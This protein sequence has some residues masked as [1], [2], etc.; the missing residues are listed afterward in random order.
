MI[1]PCLQA[2]LKE[3]KDSLD[4]TLK[5]L[6]DAKTRLREVEEGIAALQAKYE[7]CLAKKEELKE[8]CDLC[9]AR[10][11]RAEKVSPLTVLI[12]SLALM[13]S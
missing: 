1:Y 11:S 10:L 12:G 8:K 2:A 5:L 6:N 9:A 4:H 13:P 3:A 7:E